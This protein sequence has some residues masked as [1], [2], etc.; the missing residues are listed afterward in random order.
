M[1]DISRGG[2]GETFV[3]CKKGNHV[4][5]PGAS[6]FDKLLEIAFGER[7]QPSPIL[8][9]GSRAAQN[10]LFSF[11]FAGEQGASESIQNELPGH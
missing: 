10:N 1:S 8:V 11:L 6:S 7:A 4:A 9:Q 2:F 3:P 5:M